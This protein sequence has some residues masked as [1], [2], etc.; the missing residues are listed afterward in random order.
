MG[1][2]AARYSRLICVVL[3]L[4]SVLDS[5]AGR[6]GSNIKIRMD[7]LGQTG[8]NHVASGET[9]ADGRNGTLLQPGTAIEPNSIF[10]LTFY[11]REYFN[12]KGVQSFYPFVEVSEYS[13]TTLSNEAHGVYACTQ[14]LDTRMRC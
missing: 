3:L 5:S 14:G 4:R 8:F 2:A 9:D 12:G 1:T 10:K 13:P 6:P 11:T 7:Q